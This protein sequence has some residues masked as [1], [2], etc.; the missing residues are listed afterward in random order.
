[1]NTHIRIQLIG[2]ILIWILSSLGCATAVFK[3]GSIHNVRFR[4][5]AESQSDEDVRITVAV[6]SAEESKELF[7]VDLS[8]KG[9]QPVWLKVENHGE[10]PYHLMLAG[11]DPNHFSPLE[12]SYAT[13][14]GFTK[15]S[16]RKM[17]AYFKNMSFDNPIED[18]T[19]VSGFVFTNLDE[20]EKVVQ[21]DLIGPERAKF[22][23][24]FLEVPGMKAD[25][26]RVDFGSLYAEEDFVELDE[27]GLR[28]ALEKLPC[29]TTDEDGTSLGDPLNL[30]IIG[31][32]QDVVAAFARRGWLPAEET[33]STAVKKTIGS[34]LFGS[35]YR[36]SP[37]SSLYFYERHQDLARQKPRRSIH[38]R[39]HLRLWLSPMRF[40]GKP[41]WVGQISR[42][43]GVRFTV[44]TWPPVT[45]KID[46][47]V[48]EARASLIEDLV[49]SQTVG[50]VGFVKGVGRA[51]AARP[52]ENLTGDPYYTDGLRAVLVLG[53]F[54]KP[55][56]E[57]QS[58]E[59][60]RPKFVRFLDVSNTN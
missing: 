1:M 21:V 37:V 49:L 26:L 34:Y 42:D 52:R 54:P 40:E 46:P 53:R 57:I 25:Y 19:A 8:R 32:F 29:C 55:L 48:D 2:F 15:S 47:D 14:A 11:V 7:G 45:H 13:H 20:G 23:T 24:F 36:Y 9:I 16:K 56:T 44:K 31:D 17:E 30:V 43:I 58:L 60:E 51:T 59:W 41:V 4:D 5:R 39:N 33:Y 10:R 18:N 27:D 28:A 3:P 35:R 12:T 6:L 50:K 22:F 38:E